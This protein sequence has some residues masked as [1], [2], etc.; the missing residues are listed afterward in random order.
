MAKQWRPGSQFK[1]SENYVHTLTKE[2]K[3][4]KDPELSVSRVSI[5]EILLA[6][7]IADRAL[8]PFLSLLHAAMRLQ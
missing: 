4:E 5:N 6:S 8:A 1:T 7:R 3:P 2:L